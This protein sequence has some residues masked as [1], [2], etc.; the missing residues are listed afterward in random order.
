MNSFES[1][2]ENT[3]IHAMTDDQFQQWV[4]EQEQA[5]TAERNLEIGG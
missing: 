4:A 1:N 3:R 2:R 5:Y